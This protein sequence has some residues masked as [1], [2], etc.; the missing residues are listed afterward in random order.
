MLERIL[1]PVDGSDLA[2]RI[3][4]ETRGLL[5]GD[6]SQVVLLTVLPPRTSLGREVDPRGW[7][8]ALHHRLLGEGIRAEVELSIGDPAEEILRC[9]DRLDPS[10]IAMST[11]GRSGIGRWARGSVAERVLRRSRHP[12]LLANPRSLGTT[13][14]GLDRPFRRILLPLDGSQ[15]SASI[16]PLVVEVAR[17][18]ESE[19]FAIHAVPG[20]PSKTPAPY[21]QPHP[22]VQDVERFLEPQ[23]VP[24]EEAGIRHRL[25]VRYE[26]PADAILEVARSE[27]VDLVAMTT[28]GSSGVSRWV[29]GSVAEKVLREGSWPLLVRRTSGFEEAW[30]AA[31]GRAL[32]AE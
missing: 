23:L 26:R 5:K 7:L 20:I 9:A 4:F 8:D 10:L 12:L 27:H 31:G 6:G 24:F 32:P 1:V 3:L 13:L 25:M 16:V 18:Y 19:V 11:H 2:E 30:G 29:F 21:V 28:H 14:E 15:L 22:T 17:V